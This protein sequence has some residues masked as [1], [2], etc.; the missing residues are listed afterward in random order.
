MRLPE[1]QHHLDEFTKQV[2]RHQI[3]LVHQESL[4]K[5]LGQDQF[6]NVHAEG[7]E[8]PV[9]AHLDEFT[10]QVLRHQILLARQANLPGT[11]GEG[12]ENPVRAHA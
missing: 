11:L 10:R 8:N 1:E 9:C 4:P 5:T 7:G 2:L 6:I 3:L 12:G